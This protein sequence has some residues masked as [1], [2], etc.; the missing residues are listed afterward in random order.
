MEGTNDVNDSNR[1]INVIVSGL[2]SVEVTWEEFRSL[3]LTPAPPSPSYADY[4]GGRA[5]TGTLQM[6][7]GVS[8]SGRIVW[9]Q[10]EA[11]NWETLDGASEGVEYSIPFMNIVSIEKVSDD[12]ARVRLQDGREL[13]LADSNDVNLENK[14]IRIMPAAGSEVQI[15]WKTFRQVTFNGRS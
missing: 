11:F 3:E 6:A 10:D 5:L 14:G 1:G 9:D 2:G 4:D 13:L 15:D 7:N 12:V 8:M